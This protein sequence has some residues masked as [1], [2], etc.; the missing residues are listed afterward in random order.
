MKVVKCN[1]KIV[2][3]ISGCSNVA[4]YFLKKNESDKNY[5]SLKLCANCANKILTALTCEFKKE[6]TN[7]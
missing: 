1:E 2:C 5:D 3:D 7:G 4:N 6:K